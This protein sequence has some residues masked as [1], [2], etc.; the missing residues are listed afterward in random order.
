M[1]RNMILGTGSP[2]EAVAERVQNLKVADKAENGPEP[3]KPPLQ[4]SPPQKAPDHQ[5]EDEDDDDE[6]EDD[7][8]RQQREHE[9]QQLNEELAEEDPRCA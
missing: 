6:T 4:S 9:L 2:A 7:A 8:A 5:K 3:T 1:N